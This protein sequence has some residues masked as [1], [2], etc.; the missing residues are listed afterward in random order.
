MKVADHRRL[1]QDPA[2]TTRENPSRRNRWAAIALRVPDAQ[3]T[4]TGRL[5]SRSPARS[6]ISGSGM[7]T[8]LAA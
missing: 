2:F 5:R 8:L 1:R 4:I 7:F 6:R 3:H